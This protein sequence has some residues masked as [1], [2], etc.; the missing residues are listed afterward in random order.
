MQAVV[1]FTLVV[2]N[3]GATYNRFLLVHGYQFLKFKKFQRT[4]C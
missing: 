4:G 1:Q 2:M 3:G